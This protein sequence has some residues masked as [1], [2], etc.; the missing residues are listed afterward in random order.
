MGGK[1]AARALMQAAGVPVVPGDNGEGGKGFP[2]AAAAKAAAARVGYPVMLKAAAGGGGRGMRLVESE[3][4]L[5]SALAGAQ[6]EAKAA[7]GDDT[8]YLE[9]AIVRPRHIEIQVFGDEHGGAV[10]LYERDC[11]IQRRNQKVIEESPSPAIDE[12]TR[13]KMGEV[14]VRAARSVGY[15][16][17][18]TIEMLYDGASRGFYFLEM[19][20]RL[21]V[22]HP[23]TELVTGVDLVRWQLAVA[24]GERI[25]LAQEAI[26]RRGA[27]IECRVYAEDP[28]K[29]LPS[30]GTITSLRVPSGPGIRDDSGVTVGSVIS[31]H[32]DP[33]ISKLCTWAD[34]RDGAIGRMR[35]ALAE[36]HVGGIRTNLPFHRQVMRH[37]AFIAGETDTGFIERHK[38]ELAPAAPDED[39]AALAAVVAAA[40]AQA[41][42]DDGGAEG[43]LD[44]SKTEIPVWRRERP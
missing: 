15:V 41:R 25:P 9:K 44:L 7:F 34:T 37:P 20:T 17:A 1:T 11:S 29:F 23:V 36:Y 31:V 30:P 6:R 21:Q 33:M 19:N 39:A 3:D 14:A 42:G 5:E 10:H 35:R 13:A 12:A 2:N 43:G 8:V 32:Y 26:P 38:A 16:G 24:Q 40:H 22:E 28:V 4:K 18:G 27:A